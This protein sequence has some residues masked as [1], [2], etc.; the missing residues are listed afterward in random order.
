MCPRGLGASTVSWA[1]DSLQGFWTEGGGGRKGADICFM[2]QYGFEAPNA[3]LVSFLASKKYIP[4]ST[5]RPN[6]RDLSISS[7]AE[8]V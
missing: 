7:K 2:D 8:V 1:E 4:G 6:G 5:Y 3:F